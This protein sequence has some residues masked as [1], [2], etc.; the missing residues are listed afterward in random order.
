M[1]MYVN[2]GHLNKIQIA[3]EIFKLGFNVLIF[4]LYLLCAYIC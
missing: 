3:G 2:T 1:L 4:H